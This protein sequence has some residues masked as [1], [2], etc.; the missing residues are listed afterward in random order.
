M[1]GLMAIWWNHSKKSLT[2]QTRTMALKSDANCS[3]K[4]KQPRK[5]RRTVYLKQKTYPVKR[6]NVQEKDLQVSLLVS[7]FFNLDIG[8]SS[9]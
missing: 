5:V 2:W 6:K 9:Q 7:F 8:Y 3:Q 1:M 4:E